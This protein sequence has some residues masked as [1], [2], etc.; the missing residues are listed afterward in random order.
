MR[1]KDGRLC[2]VLPPLRTEGRWI[3]DGA[4]RVVLLRG[5]NLGG[6]SKVPARPDGRTHVREGFYDRRDVSFVGRPLPLEEAEDHLER[7]RAYGCSLL[8]LVITWEAVEHAGPGVYDREFLDYLKALVEIAGERGLLVWVDPHQ[9]V[10]SRWTGGDGAPAWTLEAVGMDPRRMHASGAAFL[11]Q[12]AGE[13]FPYMAWPTNY[14]RYGAATM[15]TLFFGGRVFAPHCRVE[16]RNVQEWLQDRYLGML[17]EV[18]RSL[19]GLRNVVGVGTMNEP[20]PGFIGV[21]DLRGLEN[22]MLALGPVPTGFEAMA[23]A[24]GFPTR[25]GVYRPGLGGERR[26]GE[27]VLNPEGVSVFR[28]GRECPWLVEGVWA[29]EGG[30]PVLR[31]PDY[32]ARVGGRPVS[33]EEDF[34]APFVARVAEAVRAV[35]PEVLVMA[36]GVPNG[37]PPRF[38]GGAPD[39][40]VHAFHWYDG[41]TLFTR[42]FVPWFTMEEGGIRPVLGRGAVRASFR[43]QLERRVEETFRAMGEVPC[44]VGEFGVPFGPGRKGGGGQYRRQEEALSMYYDAMDELLLGCTLWNYSA[45]NT[46]AHADGWNLE[47]LS[48]WSRDDAPEGRGWRGFVRPYLLAVAGVPLRERFARGVFTCAFRADPSVRAPTVIRLPRLGFGGAWRV[49]VSGE[50]VRCEEVPEEGVLLVWC[51][52][53]GE[54]RVRAAAV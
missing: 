30:R 10:W 46:H 5:I 9:D 3:V 23:L 29:V 47:D 43:R 20:H 35:L 25:V 37:R 41:L 8:R 13:A 11:H 40:L 16:G 53:K 26:V 28:E 17:R 38:K 44:V 24:S 54:V 50:G 22:H 36:E 32:F 51:E 27:A 7:I 14:S 18:A 34:L 21:R 45:S 31:M 15:F 2:G 49:E 48:V 19:R 6:D 1:T 52:R 39:R 42:R 12:E 33:F 4:G